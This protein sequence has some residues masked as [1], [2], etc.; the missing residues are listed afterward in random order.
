MEK[1]SKII[2]L[3]GKYLF[4]TQALF[5]NSHSLILIT[6]NLNLFNMF[7][8]SFKVSVQTI[9]NQYLLMLQACINGQQQLLITPKSVNKLGKIIL[10]INSISKE[11]LKMKK[12]QLK[13]MNFIIQQKRNKDSKERESNMMTMKSQNMMKKWQLFFKKFFLVKEMSFLQ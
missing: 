10:I 9:L 6:F 13:R 3:H 8:S 5:Q 2:R 4:K 11:S 12:K 1:I 7:L